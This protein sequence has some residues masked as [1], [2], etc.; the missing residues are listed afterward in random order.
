MTAGLLFALFVLERA[1][2]DK[3]ADGPLP[4]DV[5]VLIKSK[6]LEAA[7]VRREA[8]GLLQDYLKDATGRSDET[9]EALFKL[10]ELIWEESQADYMTRMGAHLEAVAACKE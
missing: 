3:P 4:A 9:A 10:A 1:R 8:I 6:E 5:Q 2:A 7:A